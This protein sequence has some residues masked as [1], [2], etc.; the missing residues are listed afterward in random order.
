MIAT[1]SRKFLLSSLFALA[2]SP[3]SFMA[4]AAPGDD[5]SMPGHG[6]PPMHPMHFEAMAEKWELNDDELEALREVHDDYREQQKA[7]REEH[8]QAMADILGE[9]RIEE[10][11]AQKR[12]RRHERSQARH[13]AIQE[14]LDTLYAS[15]NLDDQ[16]KQALADAHTYMR[17]RI[18]EL[19]DQEFDSREEKR[20]AWL[21]IRDEHRDAL[22]EVL[23][24][25]QID[26]LKMVMKPG[27]HG[28]KPHGKPHHGDQATD[29]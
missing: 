7:L 14:R 3:L 6:K 22:A 18:S 24:E 26:V 27:H 12:D 2:L 17:D 15:W 28:G 4:M 13:E 1:P 21:E 23:N 9:E 11:T 20:D 29:A 16:E 5:H 19:R 8:H 10:M 25:D